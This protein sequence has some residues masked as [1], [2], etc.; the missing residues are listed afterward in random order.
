M[1]VILS[2]AYRSDPAG[3]VSIPFTLATALKSDM[4]IFEY[5]RNVNS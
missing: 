3:S 4:K 5:V 1:T 2:L